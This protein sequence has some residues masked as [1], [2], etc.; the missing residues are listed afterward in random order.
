MIVPF[1]PQNPKS[2]TEELWHKLRCQFTLDDSGLKKTD[3]E[4]GF[5]WPDDL[6]LIMHS[7]GSTGVPKSI[8]YGWKRMRT[9][10]QLMMNFLSDQPNLARHVCALSF[11]TSAGLYNAIL[12]PLLTNGTIIYTPQAS[13]FGIRKFAEVIKNQN[14][15]Y[16][17]VNP[18]VLK[19]MEGIAL[20]DNLSPQARFLSCTAPL[21]HADAVKYENLFKRPVLQSYGL[22]ETLFVTVEKPGRNVDKEFSSG[23]VLGGKEAISVDPQDG[24]LLIQNNS[25]MPGYIQISNNSYNYYMPEGSVSEVVF[26]SSDIGSLDQYGRLHI[27]GRS[28]NVINVEGFKIGMEALEEVISHS[29]LVTDVATAKRTDLHGNEKPVL[30]VTSAGSVDIDAI[31][32]LCVAKLGNK[33]R[34]EEV[35]VVAEIPRTANGKINRDLIQ[36][37]YGIK[38]ENSK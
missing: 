23:E 10:A 19:L 26:K 14:A 22:T 38:H 4:S 13:A 5:D 11:C 35:I 28:S 18:T 27:S 3:I 25:I 17:W 1:P 6:A 30:L 33:A 36:K 8:P 12:V 32:N 34:P 24:N 31:K 9:N 2:Q 29:G 20:K 16:I 7:S 15:D 37:L 21:T